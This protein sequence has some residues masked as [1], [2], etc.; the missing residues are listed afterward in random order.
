MSGECGNG[1][2]F[3]TPFVGRMLLV[4]QNVRCF[5]VL[6]SMRGIRSAR[7]SIAFQSEI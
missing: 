7:V 4:A 2:K 1:F 3:S 5:S 6:G